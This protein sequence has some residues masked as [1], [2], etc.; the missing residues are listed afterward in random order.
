MKRTFLTMAIVAALFIPAALFAQAPAGTPQKPPQPVGVTININSDPGGAAV[1]IDG[2]NMGKTPVSLKNFSAGEHVLRLV[3][4]GY[5]DTETTI[6]LNQGE[7]RNIKLVLEELPD[8]REK[9][10]KAQSAQDTYE[11]A[12]EEYR[13][14]SKPKQIAGYTLLGTGL[15]TAGAAAAMFVVGT[16][17]IND[18]Y[19]KYSQTVNQDKMNKYWSNIQD[20]QK[21]NIAGYVLTATSV[22]LIGTSLYFFITMPKKPVEP[23]ITS[24]IPTPGY[25]QG[26]PFL[27]WSGSF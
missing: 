3:K 20:G 9:R 21:Y 16:K 1:T 14:I 5:V 13:A 26:M 15:A 8:T 25:V 6:S 27:S 22:V 18:N 7:T 17:Q 10:L 2:M 12:M 24:L 4:E 19:D 23:K 11:A